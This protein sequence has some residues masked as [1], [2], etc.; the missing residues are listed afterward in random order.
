MFGKVAK[1]LKWFLVFRGVAYSCL[2]WVWKVLVF[3]CSCFCCFFC[4]V[5]FVFVFCFVFVLFLFCFCFV[6]GL[7]LML[8]LVLFWGLFCFSFP[9]V[10]FVNS[11]FLCLFVLE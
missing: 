7:F 1:V 9:G 8:F 4:C 2:F 6:V 11:C 10:F 5:G 3:L